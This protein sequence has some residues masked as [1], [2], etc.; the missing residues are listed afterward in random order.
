MLG[1]VEISDYLDL[2]AA[3]A[4]YP[5]FLN[6]GVV[7]LAARRFAHLGYPAFLQHSTGIP[8]RHSFPD[9]TPPSYSR[10]LTKTQPA[11]M[12]ALPGTWE[13]YLE[14]LDKKQ[15]HESAVNCAAWS[16]KHPMRS[17]ISLKMLRTSIARPPISCLMRYD[18]AKRSFLTPHAAQMIELMQW[19]LPRISCAVLPD[20]HAAMPGLFLF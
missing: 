9:C 11:P 2:I 13:S 17:S 16:R 1:S 7:F 3:P 5:G 8:A 6:A 18:E 10:T 4:D 15:R 14:N 12:L 19:L 20:I